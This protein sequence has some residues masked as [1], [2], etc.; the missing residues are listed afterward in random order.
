MEAIANG[1][2]RRAAP[3]CGFSLLELLVA[4]S[5]MAMSLAALYHAVGTSVRGFSAA[6]RH[7]KAA[8]LAES[9]LALHDVVP[10]EG[11]Q[12]TGTQG[13]DFAWALSSAPA[14]LSIEHPAWELHR[15]EV[16]VC[17]DDRGRARCFRLATLR[18]VAPETR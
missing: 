8:L 14:Q 6:E 7:V 12:L 18:F 9:L 16:E 5:I 13:A 3:Q 2:A 1:S 4:F 10:A 11:V 17:W 15:V